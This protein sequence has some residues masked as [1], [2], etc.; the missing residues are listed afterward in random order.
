MSG[1][2]QLTE[3]RFK[4]GFR[5]TFVFL[6]TRKG[7]APTF[8]HLAALLMDLYRGVDSLFWPPHQQGDLH[9]LIL[10]ALRDLRHVRDVMLWIDAGHGFDG[11]AAAVAD[12]VGRSGA[13]L[14]MIAQKIEAGMANL[15]QL[16]DE[17]M[18]ALDIAVGQRPREHYEI[19][20]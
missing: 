2:E 4:D 12:L 16:Y 3:R 7:D 6:F 18:R 20:S 19:P 17:Y 1:M 11:Y 10:A 13:D 9:G 15:P 14:E 8:R 5:E